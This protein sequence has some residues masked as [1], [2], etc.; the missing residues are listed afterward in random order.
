MSTA[1]NKSF[2]WLSRSEVAPLRSVDSF[3]VAVHLREIVF[4]F[5]RRLSSKIR[6]I[7]LLYGYNV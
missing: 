4:G 5:G 7:R 6:R 3:L 1:R 2:K